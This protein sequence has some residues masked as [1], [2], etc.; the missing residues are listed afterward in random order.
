MF[1]HK[2]G[3]KYEIEAQRNKPYIIQQLEIIRKTPPES[4]QANPWL[5][6]TLTA[7]KPGFVRL[8]A[9]VAPTALNGFLPRHLPKKP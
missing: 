3:Y 1:E 5:F 6:F 7:P 9:G 4:F 2:H 8:Y